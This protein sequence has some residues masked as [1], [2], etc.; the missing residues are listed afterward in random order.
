[1]GVKGALLQALLGRTKGTRIVGMTPTGIVDSLAFDVT[2]SQTVSYP[3]EVSDNPLEGD[4]TFAHAIYR[5]PW[6][7]T[8]EA[9]FTD[10]PVQFLGAAF[11]QNAKSKLRKLLEF[12]DREEPVSISMTRQ[13]LLDGGIYHVQWSADA[14]IGDGIRVQVGLRRLKIVSTALVPAQFD[15]DALVAGG[16][17]ITDLGTQAPIDPRQYSGPTAVSFPAG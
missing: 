7:C 12:R 4:D 1:M 10:S 17:G 3:G 9:L 8:I 5:G 16:G 11:P 14:E 2:L 6:D 15:L 13:T